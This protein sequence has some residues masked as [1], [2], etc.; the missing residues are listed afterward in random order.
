MKSSL[1]KSMLITLSI[2]G[3]HT[4]V[5]VS[6]EESP[7]KD[8]QTADATRLHTRSLAASCVICHG[9]G[10]NKGDG[11]KISGLAGM[12]A[13]DF[14]SAIQAYKDGKR[15]SSVMHH[16]A[17]GLTTQEVNALAAYFAAQT[18]RPSGALPHQTL[19]EHHAN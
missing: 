1:V 18:P 15:P 7:P 16:H 13:S 17:K 19:A 5:F 12:D 14:V 3:L 8:I 6:A 11:T 4:P 9:S 10:G 2:I